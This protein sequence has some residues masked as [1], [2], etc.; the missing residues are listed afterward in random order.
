M[1]GNPL[2]IGAM[3]PMATAVLATAVI[4]NPALFLAVAGAFF[5]LVGLAFGFAHRATRRVTGG[6][7]A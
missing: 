5:L 4:T 1:Y 2:V 6:R 3:V 7:E